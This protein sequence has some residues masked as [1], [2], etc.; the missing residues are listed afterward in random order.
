[1]CYGSSHVSF[2]KS[3]HNQLPDQVLRRYVTSRRQVG[4]KIQVLSAQNLLKSW[5][6]K[7]IIIAPGN[8]HN[9][10]GDRR[11]TLTFSAC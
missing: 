9:N 4:D 10:K 5:A 8:S 6:D 2:L 1:M 3:A 11:P 7:I